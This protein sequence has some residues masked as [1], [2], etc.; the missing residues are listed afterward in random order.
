MAPLDFVFNTLFLFPY[1]ILYKAVKQHCTIGRAV[2][3]SLQ[4]AKTR[5]MDFTQ[6]PTVSFQL[7]C[8]SY[9][10]YLQL[11]PVLFCILAQVINNKQFKGDK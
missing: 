6:Q 10:L 5:T 11:T 2:T 4:P 1:K 7:K 9:K 3:A 8:P